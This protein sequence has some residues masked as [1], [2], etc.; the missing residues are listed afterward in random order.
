MSE[1]P[2]ST[3]SR[4]RQDDKYR[5]TMYM[6]FV[7][8]ALQQKLTGASENFDVLVSQFKPPASGTSNVLDP[9]ELRYWL[10]A[11][12]HVVSRLER[13]H[14]PLVS[15]IIHFPWTLMDNAT[16]KAHMVF[17]GML[18]SA[19]P[20]YLSLVLESIAQGLTYSS[21]TQALQASVAETSSNAVTR[22]TV[23][24]RFHA[25][26]NHILSLIPTCPSTLHPL[27]IR[28]FPHKRQSQTQHTTYIRNLLRVSTYCA[29]LSSKII[30]AIIDRALQI[31]VEIQVEI[32]DIEKADAS[33]S[34]NVFELDPFDAPIDDLKEDDDLSS[35]GSDA[36]DDAF[37]DLS[38][39]GGLDDDKP[40]AELVSSV[41]HI[42]DMMQKLDAILTLL[43]SHLDHPASTTLQTARDLLPALPP[44]ITSSSRASSQPPHTAPSTPS[45]IELPQ[46]HITLDTEATPEALL[47]LRRQQFHAL[48]GVFDRSILKTFKSRYTQFLL[49]YYSSL[50]EEFSDI[51]QGMLV[52]RALLETDQPVITRA[53]AASYIGSFVSRANYVGREATQQV[54][55]V[56]A[57]FMQDHLEAYENSDQSG[58]IND[59]I[60]FYAVTQ[61]LFLIFC[62]RWRDLLQ[63]DEGEQTASTVPGGPKKWITALTILKA[64]I[65]SSLNPLKVCS[66]NVVWQFAR[67][68]HATDFFYCYTILDSNKRVD[69]GSLQKQPAFL[70]AVDSADTVKDLN[71]FFPFDP[72]SL[73]KSL[74][75]I[76]GIFR[77]W[78]AVAIT[79][80]DDSDS[81]DEDEVEN[82][83]RRAGSSDC[84]PQQSSL[85]A[86][87]IPRSQQSEEMPLSV[88]LDAMS[89][90]PA[91]PHTLQ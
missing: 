62:F 48:L 7:R 85:T 81:E 71:T 61:A 63:D 28:H 10:S 59:H 4:I 33:D 6:S 42:Q 8:N 70:S 74:R 79:E 18:L 76:E 37:S 14:A 49:F 67:V 65:S 52:S 44:D 91:H 41:Q 25:L 36:G 55:G 54:V 46:L 90:S 34:Q 56:L 60:V 82:D 17:V 31:D 66:S 45:A 9:S 2:I 84:E 40:V 53:A 80:E 20:E 75:F 24:D 39:E 30:N 89:I 5:Q 19:R 50:D 86:M 22:R 38:S 13:P 16:V 57:D 26:L 3:N 51:F 78:S 1:R 27:L 47:S 35:D 87:L 15:A 72:Y 29:E 68:A 12:S 58:T 23:Y 88:S 21:G 11:L 83:G 64:I 73:P 69:N 32:E 77:E 43:F